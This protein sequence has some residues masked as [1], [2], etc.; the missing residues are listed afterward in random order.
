MWKAVLSPVKIILESLKILLSNKL[1]FTSILIFTTLP[2]STLIIT[3]SF[4][5]HS[6]ATQ[7]HHLEILAQYSS[8]RF[9]ARHVWQESRHDALSLLR[10]RALF[11]LPTY[12]LSLS[13]AISSVHST[14]SPTSPTLRSAAKSISINYRRP[15][16]TSIFVYAI[17][18]VFSPVRIAFSAISAS[19]GS[20]FLVNAIASVIEVYL[21]S[22]LSMGLVVAIAEERFGWDAIRV[23]SG[24]MEER[25]V[26]GWVLSGLCVMSSRLIRSKVEKLLEGQIEPP[27]FLG[28]TDVA[29]KEIRIE[30]KAVLI[31]WYGLVVLLSYVIMSVYYSD[32]RKRH[33]I[34]EAES[35][36]DE[37]ELNSLSL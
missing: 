26:C 34:K 4:S 31:G 25:R 23:G 11:S 5:L 2:L 27:D 14:L 6:R 19:T 7:I 15:F 32:C 20:I 1:V 3:Q 22:V 10:T 29:A 28:L 18:F 33:P 30:E 36:N 9:E 12:L 37:H 8:T 35:D 17:L 16:L 24:L 13:A 21:M